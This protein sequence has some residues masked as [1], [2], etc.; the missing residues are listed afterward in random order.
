MELSNVTP[1]S[2]LQRWL[3]YIIDALVLGLFTALALYLLIYARSLYACL[4]VTVLEGAYK[5]IMEWRYGA[6]LGKMAQKLVVV[7]SVTGQRMDLNQSLMRYLPWALGMF[8]AI[9][10]ITRQYQS[11]DFAEVS[12]IYGYLDLAQNSPLSDSWVIQVISNIP[13]FSAAWLIADP[14]RQALHDK[15]AKTI[16]IQRTPVQG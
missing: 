16:V 7:D 14:W 8:A 13:I 3:A 12:D 6:T 4:A 10:V 11:A 1:A 2:Y 15:L 9:F 5:P